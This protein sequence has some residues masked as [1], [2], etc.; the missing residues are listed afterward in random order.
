MWPPY[1]VFALAP[2]SKVTPY[3][4]MWPSYI[5]FALTPYSKVT[6]YSEM[7]R[8]IYTCLIT[9]AISVNAENT[10]STSDNA[11]HYCSKC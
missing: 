11:I 7:C 3:S 10:S 8:C 5:V 9:T 6:L 1:I 4:D 2:H